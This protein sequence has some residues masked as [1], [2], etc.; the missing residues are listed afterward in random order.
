MFLIKK[1]NRKEA[2]YRRLFD[3]LTQVDLVDVKERWFFEGKGIYNA[4]QNLFKKIDGLPIAY[5][6]TNGQVAALNTLAE[7]RQ[8]FA[9]GENERFLR[10]WQEVDFSHVAFG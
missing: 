3:G 10:F 9:T 2:T 7:P 8:G 4:K 5:W 1:R 6:V